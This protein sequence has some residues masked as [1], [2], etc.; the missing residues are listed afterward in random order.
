MVIKMVYVKKNNDSYDIDDNDKVKKA[1]RTL[2]KVIEY[3]VL[4][5]EMRWKHEKILRQLSNEE[6]AEYL[7]NANK[8]ISEMKK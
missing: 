6:F 2:K 7:F 8:L 3:E 4:L 5:E 1:I